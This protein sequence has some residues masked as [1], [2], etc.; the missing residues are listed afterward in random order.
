MV[1]LYFYV[2]HDELS[3]PCALNLWCLVVYISN[4]NVVFKVLV[5]L[6]IIF[7]ASAQHSLKL[8]A[9]S[10]SKFEATVVCASLF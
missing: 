7:K 5:I 10:I 8:F 2:I 6:L 4:D 9:L 1:N 3:L